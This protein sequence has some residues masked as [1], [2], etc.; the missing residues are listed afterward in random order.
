MDEKEKDQISNQEAHDLKEVSR[1]W[2][3]M[4]AELAKNFLESHGI[5]CLIRGRT[6]PFVYPFTVDGLAEF[7]VFVQAKDLERAK[8]LMASLPGAGGEAPRDDPK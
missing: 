8:E 7:K 5:T 4:E 6:P 3:P 2:G 1:V